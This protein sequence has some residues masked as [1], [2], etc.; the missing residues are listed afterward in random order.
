MSELQK[1]AGQA[2]HRIESLLTDHVARSQQR[3]GNIMAAG[4]QL[5]Q[6]EQ[7]MAEGE[8]RLQSF[9]GATANNIAQ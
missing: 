1:M 2:G 6:E 8:E 9:M 3:L 4:E 5:Q 7:M